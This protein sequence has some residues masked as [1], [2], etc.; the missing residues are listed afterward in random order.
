MAEKHNILDH[1]HELLLEELNEIS[2]QNGRTGDICSEVL[3]LFREHLREEN[4][5][6]VPLL[7][8]LKNSLEKIDGKDIP[9]LRTASERFA[10]NFKRMLE[11]HREISLKL[12]LAI[13]E[14]KLKPDEK[15]LH[16]AHELIHHVEIEEQILYPAAFAAGDLLRFER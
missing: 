3:T 14:L 5:T 11:E 6:I 10:Y 8:Y 7:G 13:G 1:E 16:L 9:I 15:A 4:E 12:N 2:Q